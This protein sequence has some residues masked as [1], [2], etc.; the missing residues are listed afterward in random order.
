METAKILGKIKK[1]IETSRQ[2][3]AVFICLKHLDL[4]E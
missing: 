4:E 1:A 3:L 2:P